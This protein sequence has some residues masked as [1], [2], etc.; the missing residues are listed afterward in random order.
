LAAARDAPG[1]LTGV[2]SSAVCVAILQS[3]A[4]TVTASGI[5]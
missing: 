4:E 5:F 3:M 2:I 1:D